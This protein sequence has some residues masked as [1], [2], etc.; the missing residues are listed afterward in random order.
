MPLFLAWYDDWQGRH[1]LYISVQPGRKNAAPQTSG[2][3]ARA[4]RGNRLN[5]RGIDSTATLTD[6][7][8][9]VRGGGGIRSLP[10]VLPKDARRGNEPFHIAYVIAGECVGARWRCLG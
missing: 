3:G 7:S 5:P 10:D 9:G 6:K 8:D 2:N 1:T 4:R